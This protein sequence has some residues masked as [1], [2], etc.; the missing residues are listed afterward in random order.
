[1]S[2]TDANVSVIS[3]IVLFIAG[4]VFI[5]QGIYYFVQKEK[6]SLPKKVKTIAILNVVFGI[7]ALLFSIPHGLKA[8]K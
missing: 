6:H 4:L 8:M 7:L 3:G 2:L 1:M 5:G